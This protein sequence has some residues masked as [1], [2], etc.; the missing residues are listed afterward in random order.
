MLHEM[1]TIMFV[2]DFSL[3]LIEYDRG[4]K[5]FCEIQQEI[6]AQRGQ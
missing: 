3:A 4:L 1:N 5:T 6:S 2:H